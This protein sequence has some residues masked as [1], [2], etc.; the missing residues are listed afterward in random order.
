MTTRKARMGQPPKGPAGERVSDYPRVGLRLPRATKNALEALAV[1]RRVPLWALVDRAVRELIARL[2]EAERARL[3]RARP[4]RRAL[5]QFK[6]EQT[7]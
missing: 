1:W 2:P 3:A 4:K 7:P 5:R 6:N